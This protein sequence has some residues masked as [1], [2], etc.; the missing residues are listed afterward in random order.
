M[1]MVMNGIVG[2]KPTLLTKKVK[3]VGLTPDLTVVALSITL[4]LYNSS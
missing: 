2:V 1:S 3:S 4:A